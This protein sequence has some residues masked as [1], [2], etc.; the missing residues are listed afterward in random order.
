MSLTTGLILL[1]VVVFATVLIISI[2]DAKKPRKA[3]SP[4]SNREPVFARYAEWSSKRRRELKEPVFSPSEKIAKQNPDLAEPSLPDPEQHGSQL[5]LSR[6]ET[7]EPTLGPAAQS[8]KA[9]TQPLQETP[10]ATLSEKTAPDKIL[11]CY[12]DGT[13]DL[14]LDY[15]AY[16]PGHEP[17]HRQQVWSSYRQNEYLMEK[18]HQLFGYDASDQAWRSL[19]QD[20]GN[21]HYTDLAV[22]LQLANANGEAS[23][24]ELTRFTQLVLR[25]AEHFSRRFQFDGSFEE[26]QVRANQLDGLRLRFDVLLVLNILPLHD[27]FL[28]P[29]IKRCAEYAGLELG[30][31]RVFDYPIDSPVLRMANLYNPGYFE[32]GQLDQ[33][34][35]HGLT[36]F[37]RVP[38]VV[39]P[40]QQFEVM[41]NKAKTIA[42]A[43]HGNLVDEQSTP[44]SDRGIQ[45]IHQQLSRLITQMRES[46]IE[47]GGATA[48]RLF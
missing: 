15:I 7:A 28:G 30:I 38:V 23:E 8:Q 9:T 41:I 10:A 24:S 37:L 3:R 18:P 20:Q 1:A 6:P 32:L 43:L 29:E 5:D 35:C 25:L 16:I 40:L 12:G 13:G 17:L 19:E 27:I 14:C 36:L 44:L 39:E 34:E 22:T 47:P 26:A 48:R 42:D 2:R 11:D 46:G 31:D 45:L 4:A 33:L 21:S